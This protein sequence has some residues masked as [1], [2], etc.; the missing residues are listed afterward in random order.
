M[1]DIWRYRATC[2]VC[3]HVSIIDREDGDMHKEKPVQVCEHFSDLTAWPYPD[4]GGNLW[5]RT[6]ANIYGKLE[7]IKEEKHPPRDSMP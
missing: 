6:V 1:P 4:L 3:G 2:P 7:I 5:F